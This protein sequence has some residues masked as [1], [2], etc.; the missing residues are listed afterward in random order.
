MPQQPFTVPPQRNMSPL[1]RHMLH[2][3]HHIHHLVDAMNE[4]HQELEHTLEILAEACAL[5]APEILENPPQPME[6]STAAPTPLNSTQILENPTQQDEI[7]GYCIRHSR[8]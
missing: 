3:S 7:P 6:T 2:F 1:A 8:H 4:V 5:I